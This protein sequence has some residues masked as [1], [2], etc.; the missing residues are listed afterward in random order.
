MAGASERPPPGTGGSAS[1]PP[2][3]LPAHGEQGI[4]GGDSGHMPPTHLACLSF[5]A[6]L[7]LQGGRFFGTRR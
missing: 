4:E 6:R 3:P 1:Y 5:L 7:K 2:R